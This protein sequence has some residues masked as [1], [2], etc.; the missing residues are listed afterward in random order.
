MSHTLQKILSI[1]KETNGLGYNKKPHELEVK[2]GTQNVA[3]ITHIDYNNVLKKLY[4]CG[5]MCSNPIGTT[6]LKIMFDNNDLY[7]YDD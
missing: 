7:K 6:Q 3:R 1:Y 4:S 2:F 5:F